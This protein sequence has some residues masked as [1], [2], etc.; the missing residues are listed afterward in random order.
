MRLVKN[1]IF[2]SFFIFP[3]VSINFSTLLLIFACMKVQKLAAKDFAIVMTQVRKL[4]V[5]L[6][7]PSAKSFYI[8]IVCWIR[9]LDI[10]T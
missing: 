1:N 3:I 9:E 6:V 7:L 8:I 4:S 10:I 2:L 5:I